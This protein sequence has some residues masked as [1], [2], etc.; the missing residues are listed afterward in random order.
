M[1]TGGEEYVGIHNRPVASKSEPWIADGRFSH[2]G[3][4]GRI[5]DIS[6]RT[7]LPVFLL[8]VI[9][10]WQ[11]ATPKERLTVFYHCNCAHIVSS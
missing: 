11:T 2:K 8:T 1:Q 7:L 6:A 4:V 10:V 5:D 9:E 3:N